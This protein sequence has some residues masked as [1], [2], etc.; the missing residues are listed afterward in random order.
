MKL[1]LPLLL[2][3]TMAGATDLYTDT[4]MVNS[5]ITK[6]HIETGIPNAFNVNRLRKMKRYGHTSIYFREGVMTK[7]SKENLMILVSE[8]KNI[9]GK[10]YLTVI[11]HTSSFTNE[12]CRIML[13]PWAEFWQNFNMTKIP[14]QRLA[15]RVN[16]RIRAVYDY[17][18][19]KGIPV[20]NLYNENRMDRDPIATEATNEGRALNQR[21]D[22]ALYR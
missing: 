15:E 12:S 4:Y 3:L 8:A 18:K 11:G 5:G 17:L 19:G 22:V 10:Y 16:V 6:G 14:K 13:S 9:K 21:V 20:K 2:T 1:L 7:K